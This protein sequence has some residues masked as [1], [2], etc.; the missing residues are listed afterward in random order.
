MSPLRRKTYSVSPLLSELSGR[1]SNTTQDRGR[2]R[3]SW[4]SLAVIGLYGS[5]AACQSRTQV[6]RRDFFLK[7]RK[8]GENVLAAEKHKVFDDKKYEFLSLSPHSEYR[9][10]ILHDLSGAAAAIIERIETSEDGV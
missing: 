9:P 7:R 1:A 10:I 4:L 5:G 3:L 8:G 2:R 6:C